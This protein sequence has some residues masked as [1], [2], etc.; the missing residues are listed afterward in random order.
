MMAAF[1][2]RQ[3]E[4]W[5]SSNMLHA[6]GSP[7]PRQGEEEGEGLSEATRVDSETPRLSPLPFSKGRGEKM[8]VRFGPNLGS[9]N[10]VEMTC[11]SR[12]AINQR[13][14]E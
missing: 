5:E 3:L 9:Q 4:Y 7:L 1:A 8:R 10:V 14:R 11:P 13:W 6:Y 2:S 12:L